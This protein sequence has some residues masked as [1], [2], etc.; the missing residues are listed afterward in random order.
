MSQQR[1]DEALAEFDELS[2][3]HP[4]PV[5]A[6]TLAGVILEAQKKPQEARKRYEQALAIDPGMPVAANNLAWMYVET[7]EN[8]DVA[9]QLAQAATR[10]LPDSPAM[11]DTLGWI[12]YKKGLARLAVP[13][14]ERSVK[15]DA[16]N[17]IYHFHLGLAYV[18]A[19]DSTKARVAFEAGPF[20]RSRFR[21]GCGGQAGARVAQGVIRRDL[22]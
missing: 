3:R 12:Y 19:G 9:L 4:R 13:P 8:L 22:S 11:Q 5:Q 15:L 6:H 14:F 18:K 10:R 1:L 7:G 17:A 20:A 16:R 21:R 2:K